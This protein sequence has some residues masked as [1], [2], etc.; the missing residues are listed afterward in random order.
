[1]GRMKML[2]LN[3]NKFKEAQKKINTV[4]IPIGTI[5]AHGEHL[6]VGT[7]ILI[8]E[9]L[10]DRIEKIIGD[11]V[12]IAPSVNYGHVWT[13]NPFPGSINISTK[14]LSEYIFEIGKSFIE[15]D[16]IYIVLL[17]GHGGNI[18]ALS[19][20]SERL[21]DLGGT[22]ITFNWWVDFKDEILKICEGQGHAGEDESSAALA[23][24][25]SHCDMTLAKYNNRRLIANIK[26]KDIGL[27]SYEH[28]MNGDATKA[29]REKGEK[30][31]ETVTAK[32]VEILREV[33]QDNI[34]IE[35]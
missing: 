7:D 10:V 24:A 17:N 29:T 22:V 30:I 18:P 9:G 32:I 27:L 4:I 19:S 28:A 8:P 3:Q 2:Y 31:L 20:V 1:M 23:V 26:K 6:P 35:S 33:W 14:I 15:S 11:H 34:F 21:A 5:E 13:L 12:L 25:E 16:F